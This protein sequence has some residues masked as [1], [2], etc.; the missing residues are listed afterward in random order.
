MEEVA[1]WHLDTRFGT[2]LATFLPTDLAP[3]CM[4]PAALNSLTHLV[5][6]AVGSASSPPALQEL[7]HHEKCSPV[8]G[9]AHLP[10][11]E[12]RESLLSTR[13]DLANRGM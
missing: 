9:S 13:V 7:Q 10:N 2:L 5:L 6:S 4:V 12:L 1:L 11:E 3:I 8:A